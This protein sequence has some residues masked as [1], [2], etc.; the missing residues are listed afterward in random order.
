MI[1]FVGGALIG[2]AAS[3]VVAQ[4]LPSRPK[5]GAALDRLGTTTAAT[6][7]GRRTLETRVASWVIQRLP[8][9][10]GFSIPEMDLA[11][12]GTTVHK[13]IYTKALW[14]V[15]GF[16]SM[17]LMGLYVQILGIL[18]FAIPAVFGLVAAATA[19]FLPDIF[20]KD[21]AAAAR[22]EFVRC[23]AVYLELVAAER[24]SGKPPA[25]AL[26]NA[27]AIGKAW[28]FIRINQELTRSRYDH[29]QPW[30][31]LVALSKDI[32]VPELGEAAKIV[33]LSGDDGASVYE[34]L[35]SS[36]QGL[37]VKMLNEEHTRA[38]KASERVTILISVLALI[39]GGVLMTP[40][41][42]KIM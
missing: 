26:E 13:F 22:K 23:V 29:T 5:L 12:V 28:P 39:F 16:T 11:L 32:S 3:L 18:P 41:I 7:G 14:A 31:A 8:S 17:I 40:L 21:K 25:I 9:I 30:D 27:A 38:N 34:A 37:R 36:G 1:V 6:D 15:G 4:A 19:W 35:R 42:L 33:R 24:R 20:L 10:P 2:L